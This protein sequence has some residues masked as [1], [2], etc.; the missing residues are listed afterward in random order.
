MAEAHR[1]G[2]GEV[3]ITSSIHWDTGLVMSNGPIST[4][5]GLPSGMT[6]IDMTASCNMAMIGTVAQFM[7]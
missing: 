5:G 4:K 3:K 6:C 7:A 2:Q 1:K